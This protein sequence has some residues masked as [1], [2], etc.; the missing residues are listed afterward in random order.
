MAAGAVVGAVAKPVASWLSRML[1][2]ML[3][4]YTATKG[5][6]ILGSYLTGKREIALKEKEV[7]G[8]LEGQR[9]ALQE[10]KDISETD[11]RRAMTLR[12]EDRAM[13][14]SE[15]QAQREE[16]TRRLQAQ[17]LA[18]MMAS[19]NI[20]AQ[21]YTPEIGQPISLSSIIGHV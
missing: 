8:Q 7:K 1:A 9:L 17:I 11:F 18:M 3:A 20:R 2:Y 5:L 15:R 12:G 19:Q 10:K 13:W 21:Q 6:D 4:S 16:E 14:M